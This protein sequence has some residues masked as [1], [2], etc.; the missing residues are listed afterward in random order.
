MAHA[1]ATSPGWSGWALLILALLMGAVGLV[2]AAGGAWLL[3]LGG[4]FYYLPA[5]LVLVA[6]AVLLWH[7][8]MAGA[9]LYAILLTLTVAWAL[10]EV[11]LNGWALVPRLGGPL[12]F[13]LLLLLLTPTLRRR[14]G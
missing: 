12:V 3:T 5:G 6:V 9:W 7:G 14:A 11:G 1:R 8:R 4:S 10:W 13:G 2:I